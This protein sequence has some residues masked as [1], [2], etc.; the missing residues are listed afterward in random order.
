MDLCLTIDRITRAREAPWP[1]GQDNLRAALDTFG[2]DVLNPLRDWF[3][4]LDVALTDAEE[5]AVALVD[6][7]PCGRANASAGLSDA[8]EVLHCELVHLALA[9]APAAA[10]VA[11]PRQCLPDAPTPDPVA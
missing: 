4:D 8:L 9:A 2:D 5:A 10:T 1:A 6:S 3:T 11:V 7:D